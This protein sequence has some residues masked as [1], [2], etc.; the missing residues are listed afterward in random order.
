MGPILLPNLGHGWSLGVMILT[1]LGMLTLLAV[2]RRHRAD[3]PTEC[4]TDSLRSGRLMLY[5]G[6]LSVLPV[7]AAFFLSHF[8]IARIF[9][10]YRYN[11]LAAPFFN[12]AL[13]G[14]FFKIPR[15]RLRAAL[16]LG[17][18]AANL[19]SSVYVLQRRVIQ[20]NDLNLLAGRP[21]GDILQPGSRLYWT[22]SGALPWLGRCRALSIGSFEDALSV[23]VPAPVTGDSYFLTHQVMGN[24][25]MLCSN[26]TLLLETLLERRKIS[27]LDLTGVVSWANAWRLRPAELPPLADAWRAARAAI[28]ARRNAILGGQTILA[29]DPAIRLGQGWSVLAIG[30]NLMPEC[31]TEGP[32][33]TLA[34]TGP[35]RPGRYRLKM[36]FWRSHPYPAKE[37]TLR[38]RLPG[39]DA[40]QTQT[41]GLDAVAIEGFVDVTKSNQKLHLK[42]ET[43]TWVPAEHLA[44]SVDHRPLGM[45]FLA[46]EMRPNS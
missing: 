17:L 7:L 18:L 39:Q 29:D 14:L 45:L 37:I 34:W 4:P 8:H 25:S 46:L 27:R 6:V 36:M 2:A 22:D 21:G 31:W 20:N 44:G 9:L 24:G 42:M 26:E 32:S 10:G 41:A 1:G 38:Y 16:L 12:L 43:P 35:P 19:V 28:E 5:A 15:P 11:L 23:G 40:W 33:Q 13:L 3:R 30:A